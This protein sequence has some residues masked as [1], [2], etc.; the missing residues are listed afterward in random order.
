MGQRDPNPIPAWAVQCWVD[1]TNVYVALP[2][3]AGG[4]SYIT[5]YPLCEGGLS[6]A[7]GVLRKRQK[8]IITPSAASP[9]N[10]TLPKVQPQVE[11]KLTAAQQRLREETTESQRE[12]ARKIL[13][14]MGI[15]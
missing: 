7:L 13:A 1:E 2:M 15:K 8:E 9:A 11:R 12:N 14:K 3:T 5:K 6:M 4:I 10:Y